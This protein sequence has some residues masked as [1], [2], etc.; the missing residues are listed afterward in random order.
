[1]I[2]WRDEG[3][4]LS[5]RPHGE[6]A[7]ILEL[8]T[9][10]HGRHLGIVHGGV[11]RRK[12]PMLQPGNQVDAVWKARLEDH[13]GGFS[14]ELRLARAAAVLS[15]PLRLSALGAITALSSLALPE[16]EAQDG[17]ARRTE[18]L[19]DALTEG[20]GWLPDYVHWEIALLEVSGFGLD[21]TA[22]AGGGAED[23]LAFVSPRTGRAVSRGAAG[24]WASRLIPLP[25]WLLGD[26]A[27]VEGVLAALDLTG[28]FLTDRLAPSLG[29]RP[30]PAAR[31]RFVEALRRA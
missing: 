13:L 24:E 10:S 28:Y 30:L 12:A 3:I 4:V 18:A 20:E 8:L 6:T 19:C 2:E 29:D 25:K 5:A 15:D 26:V 23:D 21:F 31:M 16:R 7:V 14:V 1:M 9:R 17:F 22:C 27:D 11:S